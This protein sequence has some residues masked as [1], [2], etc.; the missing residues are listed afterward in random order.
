M[1]AGG[2]GGAGVPTEATVVSESFVELDDEVA[3]YHEI[4]VRVSRE[5][6]RSSGSR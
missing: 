5:A 4:I 1:G 2:S 3:G 6:E